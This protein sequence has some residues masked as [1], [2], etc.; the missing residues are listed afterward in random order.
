MH[1]RCLSWRCE[2]YWLQSVDFAWVDLRTA[3]VASDSWTWQSR[4]PAGAWWLAAIYKQLS[5]FMTTCH[6]KIRST[7]LLIKAKIRRALSADK[8]T[9]LPFCQFLGVTDVFS[10]LSDTG[11]WQQCLAQWFWCTQCV[12]FNAHGRVADTDETRKMHQNVSDDWRW[13]C[14]IVRHDCKIA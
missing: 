12:A 8:L 5:T 3:I 6:A 10:G 2:R 14:V 1:L 4:L 11:L 9:T 13:S 7:A